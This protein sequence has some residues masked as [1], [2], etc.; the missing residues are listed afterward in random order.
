MRG[1]TDVDYGLFLKCFAIVFPIWCVLWYCTRARAKASWRWRFLLSLILAAAF[2]PS[3]PIS[4]CG[5]HATILPAAIFFGFVVAS[6]SDPLPD[7][8][9]AMVLAVLP[10]ISW[11]GIT[12]AV[13]SWLL[14]RGKRDQVTN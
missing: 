5:P 3:F 13:W 4:P 2:A 12:Y 8:F 14:R 6:I 7:V 11:G 9:G 1:M 10:I